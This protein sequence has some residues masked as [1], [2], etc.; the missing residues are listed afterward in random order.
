MNK[1]EF[2]N[3][4]KP[5]IKECI[6]EV[7]LEENGV[8]AKVIAETVNGF[9]NTSS[10]VLNETKSHKQERFKYSEQQKEDFKR[11]GQER[12][13]ALAEK[14]KH[15]ANIVGFDKVFDNVTPLANF[16]KTLN[17]ASTNSILKMD[18]EGIALK[19]MSPNDP[20]VNINGILN[21]VGGSSTWLK[22][23]KK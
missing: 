21:I 13:N 20:G 5:L 18:K 14:A 17:E 15:L 1:S 16:G 23:L 7:L 3:L 11:L 9:N 10:V 6:K 12:Q 22:Q 4:L 19:G 2:K 8:L